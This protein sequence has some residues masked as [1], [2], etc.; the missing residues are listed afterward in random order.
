MFLSQIRSLVKGQDEFLLISNQ[1]LPVKLFIATNYRPSESLKEELD[2]SRTDDEIIGISKTYLE[3]NATVETRLLT[4]DTGPMI[5]A[6]DCNI[7]LD[8][9]PND[10][11]L[12]AENDEISRENRRLRQKIEDLRAHEPKFEVTF[13]NR[14]D[15]IETLEFT[16]D[17]YRA[18]NDSE[19]DEL[20]S[21]IK[22]RFPAQSNFDLNDN[23]NKSLAPILTSFISPITPPTEEEIDVYLKRKYPDWINEC[24]SIIRSIPRLMN[25]QLPPIEFSFLVQNKGNSPAKLVLITVISRGNFQ[26][27]PVRSSTYDKLESTNVENRFVL[28]LPPT[29]PKNRINSIINQISDLPNLGTQIASIQPII[30]EVLPIS[31]IY[32]DSDELLYKDNY[33]ES[34]VTGFSL[35]CDQWRHKIDAIPILGR[36]CLDSTSQKYEGVLEIQIHAENLKTPFKKH[37]KVL[38][39]TAFQDSARVGK[40]LIEDLNR[41][42]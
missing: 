2:Y 15:R 37:V 22:D 40:T 32:R 5:T 11:L 23:Y 4:H 30:P 18:L 27:Q 16:H 19:I 13:E 33:F 3:E 26:I 35:K 14:S 29:P 8:E 12:P 7:Q 17:V 41:R 1:T 24:E 21:T 42:L 31:R 36:L 34:P 38:G 6:K 28:P 20:I 25:E 9:I 10:W 39:N